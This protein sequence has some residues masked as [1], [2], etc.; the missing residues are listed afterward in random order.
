[1]ATRNGSPGGGGPIAGYMYREWLKNILEEDVIPSTISISYG[2][3]EQELPEQYAHALCELFGELAGRGVSVLV[4]SGQDGVGAGD[5]V[6]A[7]GNFQFM[8]EFPASCTYANHLFRTLDKRR[9][10]S[11]S[12]DCHALQVPIP[13]ASAE[14]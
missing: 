1:M 7:Y 5:C 9:Y 6:N 14:P 12:L 4:A 13:Q 11:R 8:P 3:P 10:K 2:Q